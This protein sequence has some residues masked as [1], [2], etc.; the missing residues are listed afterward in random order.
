MAIVDE[1]IARVRDAT[2]MVQIVTQHL[3]LKRVGS[4]WV[5]L[6]P[7]HQE[8]SPSFSVN[9]ELGLYYCFGCRA[10][11]DAIRFVQEME[12]TD[13]VGAVEH[14]ANR[15]GITLR[16]TDAHQGESRKERNR[17]VETIRKAADYYHDRL[18][19]GPDAGAARSYLRAR[20]FDG[21]MVRKYGLGWAPD[22]WDDLARH[23]RLPDKVLTDAGLGLVNRIGKQQD[24]FRARVL[25]PIA[26]AQGDVV[27][28]GGR[29]LPDGEGPKY[30]NT[31]ETALYH[32]SRVLYGLDR[33]KA[34][35]VQSDQVII[36]EGY[37]DVIGFARVGL[38]IAVATCGTALTEDHVKILRRFTQ[39][40]VLAFDPDA[41]GQAAAE[42]VYE[43]EKRHDLE[44]SVVLLP[45]GD[46]P[47]DLAQRD[48][49]ALRS[50]VGGAQRF[51]GFRVE[52]VLAVGDFTSP[53]GR[54]RVAETAAMRIAEH[55]DRL[56]REP[57][58]LQVAARCRVSDEQLVAR[59]EHLRDHPPPKDERARTRSPRAP[60]AA[61]DRVTAARRHAPFRATPET[62]ALRLAVHRTADMLGLLTDALF[63]DADHL[64]VFRA[65]R[66]TAGDARAA[67]DRLD[68]QGQELL[69]RVAVEDTSAEPAD[70][71]TRLVVRAGERAMDQIE[72]E[73]RVSGDPL[74]WAQLIGWVKLRLE[75]ASDERNVGG[76]AV[77][78]LVAWLTERGAEGA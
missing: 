22:R 23:L 45:A 9:A 65:L 39:R 35:I 27:G 17:L 8:N 61:E 3:A 77:G 74:A 6:C 28:F 47:A 31:S 4:R 16:Y 51:L 73:A 30:K 41:A 69:A 38:P 57:Y 26:D 67:T 25:F 34:E 66:E 56:V 2:D 58:A 68:E 1:D 62:E 11:G 29:K 71:L 63:A 75:E 53:E 36:C 20:G 18:L 49:E 76:D 60:E 32:K 54:A 72:R 50:A 21:E 64:A 59:V 46:D 5:G 48:P 24:F 40:L 33:A 10:S 13:F 19:T 44:V 42:R 14:L 43:W 15:A 52:Q 7:F 78:Q 55:P 12:H 70:V 37:T